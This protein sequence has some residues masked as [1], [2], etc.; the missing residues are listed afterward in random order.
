MQGSL[1]EKLPFEDNSF[2]FINIC[3]V[4][5]HLSNK[6]DFTNIKHLVAEFNRVLKPGCY[7]SL[8]HCYPV[9]MDSYWYVKMLEDSKQ[10]LIERSVDK[11]EYE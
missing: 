9:H 10:K 1:L 6:G 7:Y 5:H 3:Q 2:D 8:N 4:I 11:S